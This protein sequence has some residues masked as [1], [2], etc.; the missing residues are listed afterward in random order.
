MT[1]SNKP[2]EIGRA[3]AIVFKAPRRDDAFITMDRLP[4]FWLRHVAVAA[5]DEYGAGEVVRV[6]IQVE[7]KTKVKR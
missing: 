5:R 1:L 4:I 7:R 2:Q 3:W 6:S